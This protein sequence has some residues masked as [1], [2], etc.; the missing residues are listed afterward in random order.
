MQAHRVRLNDREL[1]LI[2]S[3]LRARSAGVSDVRAA[4]IDRLA[5]RLAEGGP[6]NPSLRFGWAGE[7]GP[8]RE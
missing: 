6:G 1:D 8:K 5:E 4:E 3:A 2:V 7:Y